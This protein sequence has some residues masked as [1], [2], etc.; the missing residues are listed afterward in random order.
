MSNV[1]EDSNIE[2]RPVRCLSHRTKTLHR[3]RTPISEHE[4]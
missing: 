4:H 1:S 2:Q 3:K